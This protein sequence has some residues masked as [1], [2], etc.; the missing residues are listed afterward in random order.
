MP[1]CLVALTVNR[2][3]AF[4]P[5]YDDGQRAWAIV[6]PS[7]ADGVSKFAWFKSRKDGYART[8]ISGGRL[9]SMHRW[10][11][12]DQPRH[13][14]I[15]HINGNRIDNRRSNLRA[16]TGAEN[17]RNR[18]G[19][20]RNNATSG[21]RNVSRDGRSGKWRVHCRKDGKDYWGGSFD[22]LPEAARAAERLRRDLKFPNSNAT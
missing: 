7:D 21:I 10:L 2:A 5:L 11:M 6:D 19:A 14:V 3:V 8:K 9:V 16:V 12:W 4:V 13:L 18:Q 17:G 1:S 22:C 15:D 20:N